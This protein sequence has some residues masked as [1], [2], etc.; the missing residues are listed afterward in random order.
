MLALDVP[1][2]NLIQ[3]LSEQEE[4][5]GVNKVAFQQAMEQVYTVFP[6]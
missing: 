4:S 6:L 2:E 5:Y 3:F 1:M